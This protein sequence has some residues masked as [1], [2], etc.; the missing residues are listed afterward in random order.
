MP[1][2]GGAGRVARRRAAGADGVRLDRARLAGVVLSTHRQQRH[3][4][5]RHRLVG[6]RAVPARRGAGGRSLDRLAA[7]PHREVGVL[8]TI[9]PFAFGLAG[10]WITPIAFGREPDADPTIFALF[11][12]TAMA[13]SSLPVIAKTLLDL[14]LYRTDLGMVV[15]SAAIFNDLIGWTVFAL[16]LGMMGQDPHPAPASRRRWR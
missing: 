16:I 3:R 9:I 8:G 5:R 13:I 15:V 6:D 12:A 14:N 10:A 11:L 1:S 7:G 2:A 4:P